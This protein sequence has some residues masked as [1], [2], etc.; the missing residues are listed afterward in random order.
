MAASGRNPIQLSSPGASV[1]Q[2]QGEGTNVPLPL[3]S[4][5]DC[6]HTPE[7]SAPPVSTAAPALG[8]WIGLVPQTCRGPQ[9]WVL[10]TWVQQGSTV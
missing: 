4:L 6:C 2:S 8:N 10:K 5:C 1:M 9:N 7:C 3:G